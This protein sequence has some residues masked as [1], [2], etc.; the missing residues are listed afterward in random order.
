VPE[1]DEQDGEAFGQ[2]DVGAARHA[3]N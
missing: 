3:V 1:D 2:V